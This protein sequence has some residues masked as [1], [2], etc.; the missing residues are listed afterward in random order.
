[1]AFDPAQTP[2]ELLASAVR[3]LR[4]EDAGSAL[5]YSLAVASTQSKVVASNVS[6]PQAGA[7]VRPPAVAGRFYPASPQEVNQALDEMIPAARKPE[8]WA[9]AMIPHAG[10]MYSGRLA[11][12]VLGRVEI[13]GRVI[14][15]C[16]KHSHNGADWAVAPHETWSMPGGNVESDPELA[17][18]LAQAIPGLELDAAAHALEHAIEVQLPILARLAPEARVVGITMHGGDL[19]SLGQFAERLADV[20]R[21]LPERPLLVIST[22]MNHYADDQ[23]T[24]RLDRMALDALETLDPDRL[25]QTV[26]ENRIS[27]CGV[28]AAVTVM[29]TLQKLDALRRFEEVGY[30]TSADASGDTRRVVGYAGVLL[31]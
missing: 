26:S 10:W 2:A 16:P 19:A 30:A 29:L 14:V 9:A 24:R 28:L 4:V 22:D 27:M 12:A 17:R 20:L 13:P 11:A 15:F 18:Q 25:Y 5:I 21:G 7:A 23:R 1:M 8:P 6:Q 31:G 3:Q